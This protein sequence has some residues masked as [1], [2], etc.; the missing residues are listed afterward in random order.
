MTSIL[1]RVALGQSSLT[2]SGLQNQVQG[3]LKHRA[4]GT[5]R[6][7]TPIAP[8]WAKLMLTLLVHSQPQHCGHAGPGTFFVVRTVLCIVHCLV[9]SWPLPTPCHS[10]HT[11]PPSAVITTCV[12]RHGQCPLGSKI[13]PH[14]QLRTTTPDIYKKLFFLI[15]VFFFTLKKK[16]S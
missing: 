13:F 5:P 15:R 10:T 4:L 2:F 1:E 16:P 14:S 11:S 7:Y 3:C 8:R 6:V 9:V 12:S